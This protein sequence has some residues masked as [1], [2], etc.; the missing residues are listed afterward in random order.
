MNNT[1]T[2]VRQR[3]RLPP[4]PFQAIRTMRNNHRQRRCRS[5]PPVLRNKQPQVQLLDDHYCIERN[6]GGRKFVLP[7]VPTHEDD[8]A[9]DS[10]DF[11]N[12]IVLIPIVALNVMNW[13][14]DVL[15]FNIQQHH[16]KQQSVAIADA[17]TGEWFDVF[18]WAT[19]LYF[20][21]DMVWIM[22]VPSS[23]KSPSVI[24]QHHFVTIL[25]ILIP[26]YRPDVRWCMG[27][28]MVRVC[29]ATMMTCLSISLVS[30]C[31]GRP[32]RFVRH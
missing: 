32:L 19:L 15:L 31:V 11:F 23:V 5:A 13:N 29:D 26:F 6:E 16:Q 20:I 21:T 2:T 14:W 27:A 7:G 17:W 22:L 10:H 18:F 25:Y 1:T 12:L 4:S 30:C 3:R 8:W 28:C 24:I 9:R